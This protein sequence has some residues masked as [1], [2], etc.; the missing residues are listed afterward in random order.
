MSMTMQIFWAIKPNY[1][2]VTETTVRGKTC[3]PTRTH[4]PDSELT[5]L[6]SFSLMLCA[7]ITKFIVFGIYMSIFHVL[8]SPF[9][10]SYCYKKKI[11]MGC[12]N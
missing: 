11:P 10:V 7:T 9:D 8:I 6:C 12:P 3:C 2:S 5:S 4:Y 1:K